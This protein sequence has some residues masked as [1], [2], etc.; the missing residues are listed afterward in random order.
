MSAPNRQRRIAVHATERE[1]RELLRALARCRGCGGLAEVLLDGIPRCCACAGR[2]RRGRC[3]SL[4]HS[5]LAL[6]IE[7]ACAG[8]ALALAGDVADPEI[9]ACTPECDH[10]R[11]GH[12][13]T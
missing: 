5:E 8:A 13:A 3:S 7:D 4:A 6:R 1:W 9:G 2:Y 10:G 11:G 12:G